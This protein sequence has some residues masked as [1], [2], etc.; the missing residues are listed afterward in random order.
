MCKLFRGVGGREAR[1]L[2]FFYRCK[3]SVYRGSGVSRENKVTFFT[4]PLG[5]MKR[6][7]L[8]LSQQTITTMKHY[9]LLTDDNVM[10]MVIRAT[11][12]KE[13]LK[14][15]VATIN[16]SSI[17]DGATAIE[18]RKHLIAQEKSNKA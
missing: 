13:A 18:Y 10:R 6:K 11:N 3:R 8:Y 4:L 17:T 2:T 9:A 1:G 12:E 5:F 14:R 16:N 7:P 15:F